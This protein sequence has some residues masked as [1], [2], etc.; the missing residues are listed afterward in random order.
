MT[1]DLSLCSCGRVYNDVTANMLNALDASR[2]LLDLFSQ[3]AFTLVLWRT[4]VTNDNYDTFQQSLIARSLS[5][6]FH[7]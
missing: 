4:R 6:H 3:W 5:V 1:F 2:M 7:V